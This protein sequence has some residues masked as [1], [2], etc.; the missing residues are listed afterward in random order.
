[1]L[2]LHL[3]VGAAQVHLQG[4]AAFNP[5]A[6]CTPLPIRSADT[7]AAHSSQPHRMSGRASGSL[8]QRRVAQHPMRVRCGF[9]A[10]GGRRR[11][12]RT[13][14][15]TLSIGFSE[16][17]MA[18]AHLAARIEC[19]ELVL[20]EGVAVGHGLQPPLLSHESVQRRPCKAQRTVR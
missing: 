16:N 19:T 7:S 11:L 10:G 13:T 12:H 4:K 1:V 14:L 3:R 5:P 20:H 18:Q 17:R 9:A 8:R 15:G 6:P 2:S